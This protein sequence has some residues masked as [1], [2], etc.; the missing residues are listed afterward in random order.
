MNRK[1]LPFKPLGREREPQS[2]PSGKG[3][4]KKGRVIRYSFKED[5]AGL[6]QRAER[7]RTAEEKWNRAINA[8]R[9]KRDAGLLPENFLDTLYN[10]VTNLMPYWKKQ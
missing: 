9:E 1:L 6:Q 10:V 2:K 4:R 3:R 5:A 8:L 7:K